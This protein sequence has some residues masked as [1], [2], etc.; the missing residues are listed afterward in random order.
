VPGAF[1]L[2]S[3]DDAE[4]VASKFGVRAVEAADVESRLEALE[5]TVGTVAG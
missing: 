4:H 1:F 5:R 2:S 3:G